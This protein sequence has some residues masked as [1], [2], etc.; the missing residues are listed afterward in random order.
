MEI[1]T[2]EDAALDGIMSAALDIAN[3]DAAIR[4]DLKT[5]LLNDDLAQALRCACALVGLEPTQ[6]VLRV[7]KAGKA[8]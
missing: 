7:E 2:S 5:A 6:A 3:R 1:V 8:A 4:R